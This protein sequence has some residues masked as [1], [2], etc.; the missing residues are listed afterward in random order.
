GLPWELYG[1]GGV[2]ISQALAFTPLAY[3]MI[4]TTM[5]SL[6]PNLEDSA[7][8]MGATE[9]T[10]LRT[11]TIPLLAP[12]LLKAALLIFVLTIAEFGNAAILGGRPPFLAPDT[13][14]AITGES[15]F[16]MGSVLSVVLIV[17]CLVAFVVHARLLEGKQYVTIGGKPAASEP[18]RI[19]PL[20]KVPLV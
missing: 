8:D 6:D 17:P 5:V 3:M 18:R 7:Y 10:I 4:E 1:F 16:N 2:A 19:S 14:T 9:S 20:I 13:Y 11:I 15:D 12:G